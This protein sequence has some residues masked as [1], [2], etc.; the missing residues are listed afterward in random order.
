[1]Q[2]HFFQDTPFMH[3]YDCSSYYRSDFMVKVEWSDIQTGNYGNNNT[4][5]ILVVYLI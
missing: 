4:S 2:S 1:M 3:I 5:I